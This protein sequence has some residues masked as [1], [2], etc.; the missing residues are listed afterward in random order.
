[1][2][3]PKSAPT[4]PATIT[5]AGLPLPQAQGGRPSAW[6]VTKTEVARKIV[7]R[8]REVGRATV[9]VAPYHAPADPEAAHGTSGEAVSWP[10]R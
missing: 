2:A 8:L 6:K 10:G 3:A 7:V 1:M 5:L 9:T 4:W